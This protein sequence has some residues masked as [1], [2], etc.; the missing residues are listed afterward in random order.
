MK[1][2]KAVYFPMPA[3][4]PVM[5]AVFPSSLAK[6]VHLALQNPIAS[7]KTIPN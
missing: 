7:G 4:H 3:L 6:E 1:K 5:I 2:S